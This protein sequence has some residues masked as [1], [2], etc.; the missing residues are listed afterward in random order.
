[1]FLSLL[2]FLTLFLGQQYYT[3][4]RLCGNNLQKVYEV[5]GFASG[6]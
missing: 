2:L 1:M 6:T 4:D 5:I 3:L